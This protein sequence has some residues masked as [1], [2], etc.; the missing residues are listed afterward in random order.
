MEVAKSK[1]NKGDDAKKS[2]A[3]TPSAEPSDDW[4]FLEPAKFAAPVKGGA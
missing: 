4:G 3:T 1:A 2:S